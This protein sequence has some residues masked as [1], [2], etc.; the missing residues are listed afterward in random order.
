MKQ[1][2]GQRQVLSLNNIMLPQKQ[3]MFC[4]G[5]NLNCP[6]F[7]FQNL[8]VCTTRQIG[9]QTLIHQIGLTTHNTKVPYQNGPNARL[10]AHELNSCKRSCH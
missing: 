4:L 3:I 7:Q 1:N 6:M 9:N 5:T 8:S 10:D 2:T